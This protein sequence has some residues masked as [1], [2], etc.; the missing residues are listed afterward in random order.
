MADAYGKELI[1]DLHECDPDTFTRKNIEKF[2]VELCKEINMNSP[3]SVRRP[4]AY[5]TIHKNN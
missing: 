3:K 2:F 5:T 4:F 1:I